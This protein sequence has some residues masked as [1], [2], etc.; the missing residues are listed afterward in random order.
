MSAAGTAAAGYER[1]TKHLHEM[2]ATERAQH[3]ATVHGELA[4]VTTQMIEDS[5]RRNLPTECLIPDYLRWGRSRMACM[6]FV[7]HDYPSVKSIKVSRDGAGSFAFLPTSKIELRPQ[8]SGRF[9]LVIVPKWLREKLPSNFSS[10]IPRLAGD[11]WSDTERAEW[12]RLIIV[13]GKIN[14]EIQMA[15]RRLRF[16]KSPERLPYG[17]TA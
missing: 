13:C 4:T 2:T 11:D 10:V 1:P 9:A 15:P 16:R 3:Y 7:R 14:Y 5:R 8:S 12:D 17:Y 6:L